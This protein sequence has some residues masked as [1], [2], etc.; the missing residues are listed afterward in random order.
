MN[1]GVNHLGYLGIDTTVLTVRNKNK[2]VR[3]QN[4]NL[5]VRCFDMLY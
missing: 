2:T 4:V 5:C 1:K 3:I